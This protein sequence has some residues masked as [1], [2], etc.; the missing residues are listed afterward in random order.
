[1][2]KHG[3]AVTYINISGNVQAQQELMALNNG[4]ASVPT[5]IFS[6]GSQLTEPSFRALRAKLGLPR[7]NVWTWLRSLFS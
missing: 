5:L 1:M 7:P 2:K 4:Y 3:V 6:D